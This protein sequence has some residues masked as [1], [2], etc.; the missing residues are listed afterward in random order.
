METQFS[1]RRHQRMRNKLANKKER[2]GLHL[3]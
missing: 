3:L 2:E 1:H